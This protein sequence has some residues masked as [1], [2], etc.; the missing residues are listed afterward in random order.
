MVAC[1]GYRTREGRGQDLTLLGDLS[2]APAR[3][4][5]SHWYPTEHAATPAIHTSSAPAKNSTPT[6]AASET[7]AAYLSGGRSRRMA[8]AIESTYV[9]MNDEGDSGS[10][11][12][13]FHPATYE[14]KAAAA[15]NVPMTPSARSGGA[16]DDSTPRQTGRCRRRPSAQ[17]NRLIP[18]VY[19]FTGANASTKPAMPTTIAAAGPN[20]L[21][22]IG[23]SGAFDPRA[24]PYAR[25]PMV[26]IASE[27]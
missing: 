2:T 5:T 11:S 26:A 6:H 25:V 15:H 24:R 27:T 19:A 7:A 23:T 17:I 9:A 13:M 3:R 18:A 12:A 4:V 22:A 21:A 20:V 8:A 10:R 14:S 16:D 1:K